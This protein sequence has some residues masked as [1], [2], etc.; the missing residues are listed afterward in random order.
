MTANSGSQ[1]NRVGRQD[2]PIGDSA[3]PLCDNLM[4]FLQVKRAA[5][6]TGSDRGNGFWQG[7]FRFSKGKASPQPSVSSGF[8]ISPLKG[9]QRRLFGEVLSSSSVE[10]LWNIYEFSDT[11]KPSLLCCPS[12]SAL[13]SRGAWLP[14]ANNE[15]DFQSLKTQFLT[16]GSS[17]STNFPIFW[18]SQSWICQVQCFALFLASFL[19]VGCYFFMAINYVAIVSK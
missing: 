10:S 9:N 7:I 5:R 15:H 11:I 18:N 4:T 14:W 1:P 17:I 16:V 3:M 12:F 13:P 19:N 8:L 2:F 6:H